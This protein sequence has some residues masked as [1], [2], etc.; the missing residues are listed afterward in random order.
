MA[1]IDSSFFLFLTEDEDILAETPEDNPPAAPE[2]PE[3]EVKEEPAEPGE[4][5]LLKIHL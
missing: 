2:Q 4:L 3:P 1:T 5:V